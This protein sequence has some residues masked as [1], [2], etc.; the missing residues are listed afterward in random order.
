MIKK[1]NCAVK[2][3]LLTS[4]NPPDYIL[5]RLHNVKRNVS[6]NNFTGFTKIYLKTHFD[7]L[8]THLISLTPH[9]L[10]VEDNL[11][12]LAK[13]CTRPHT[14]IKLSTRLVFHL[15]PTGWPDTQHSSSS[16]AVTCSLSLSLAYISEAESVR[17]SAP[18]ELMHPAGPK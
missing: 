18:P 17:G 15:S 8:Q 1:N 13:G 16:P 5:E 2:L 10:S 6:C 9:L 3:F 12:E 7:L 14:R 4:S 11:L